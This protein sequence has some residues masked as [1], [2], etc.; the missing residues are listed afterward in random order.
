M[1]RR[2]VD[3]KPIQELV[4]T[5]FLKII[6]QQNLSEF[7]SSFDHF[8]EPTIVSSQCAFLLGFV[9]FRSTPWTHFVWSGWV[10]GDRPRVP[11]AMVAHI[12]C[13]LQS[14]ISRPLQLGRQ[15]EGQITN[16]ADAVLHCL[17]NTNNYEIKFLTSK[18]NKNSLF[19]WPYWASK[20]KWWSSIYQTLREHLHFSQ[21][22]A[23]ELIDY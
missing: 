20:C 23:I 19:P 22:I 18:L 7:K 9:L 14:R 8:V 10:P 15:M 4:E 1:F 5:Q 13:T 3:I 6:L 12:M 16:D 2:R 11:W 21:I 17:N